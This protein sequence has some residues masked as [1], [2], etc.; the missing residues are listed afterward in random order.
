MLPARRW[1]GAS[2]KPPGEGGQH[3]SCLD[4]FALFGVLPSLT[5]MAPGYRELNKYE[6]NKWAQRNLVQHDV[7]SC[8]RSRGHPALD[9]YYAS[10]TRNVKPGHLIGMW[11]RYALSQTPGCSAHGESLGHRF[12]HAFFIPGAREE[13][14]HK[15]ELTN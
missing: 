12:H 8:K 10:D 1:S 14:V 11:L 3:A 2:K 5:Q 7:T 13:S 15:L 6:A 9:R 4:L